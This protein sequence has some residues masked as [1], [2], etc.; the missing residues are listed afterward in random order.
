V[1]DNNPDTTLYNTVL[2]SGAVLS[3]DGISYDTVLNGSPSSD[4]LQP[5]RDYVYG[6]A[7]AYGTTVNSGTQEED[8][9]GITHSTVVN[10]GG[11]QAVQ[12]GG[13]VYQTTV[14]N[15]GV[16]QVGNIDRE[17]LAGIGSA[18]GTIINSGGQENVITGGVAYGTDI[19]SG[20]REV[21]SGGTEY[22][23]KIAG[24]VLEIGSGGTLSSGVSFS[25][26]GGKLLIDTTV[27][28]TAVISGFALGDTI[29]LAAV[30]YSSA[31]TVSVNSPGVVTVSAGGVAY[32]LNISGAVVGATNFSLSSATPGGGTILKDPPAGGDVARIGP[33]ISSASMAFLTPVN[34]GLA[35]ASAPPSA[36]LFALQDNA[37]ANYW[38]SWPAS[39]DPLWGTT[40]AAISGG[41]Q[42]MHLAAV[43]TSS[44][45]SLPA[46]SGT[47]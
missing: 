30:A 47:A 16:E 10:S 38:A 36:G 22:S 20:G 34:G 2:N 41:S 29:Q 24:G 3:L 7:V 12:S 33:D 45:L 27:M 17:G 37:P 19:N 1:D 42:L 44:S 26:S 11:G 40:S 15:G 13:I 31:S 8:E 14:N 5:T 18:S 6:G 35:S 9:G 25:G 28:P 21:V 4:G 39:S 43:V 23:A 32:N 46:I